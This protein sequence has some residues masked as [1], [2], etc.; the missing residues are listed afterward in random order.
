MGAAFTLI[1]IV[2]KGM[3]ILDKISKGGIIPFN[4]DP[5]ADVRGEGSNA[6]K[7]KVVIR[8]VS[9]V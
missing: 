1:G 3:D 4:G 5:T 8:D 6:P 7:K 2:T 9:I